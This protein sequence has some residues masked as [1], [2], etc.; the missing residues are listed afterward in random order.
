MLDYQQRLG[1]MLDETDNKNPKYLL[2]E[3]Q[4]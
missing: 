1:Y 3:D 2:K 4:I